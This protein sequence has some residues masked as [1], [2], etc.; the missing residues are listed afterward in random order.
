LCDGITRE[1]EG[2]IEYRMEI[3]YGAVIKQKKGEQ[4]ERYKVKHK[5]ADRQ[6]KWHRGTNKQ[7]QT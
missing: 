5:Q 7:K 2:N 3:Q 1:G 4:R 6:R